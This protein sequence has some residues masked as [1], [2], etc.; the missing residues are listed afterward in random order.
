MKNL[1]EEI[2]N[3]KEWNLWNLAYD[4]LMDSDVDFAPRQILMILEE[5]GLED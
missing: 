4:S 1:L 3:T 5:I 2:Y